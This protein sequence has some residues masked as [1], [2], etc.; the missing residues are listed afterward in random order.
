MTR[1]PAT[2]PNSALLFPKG[3]GLECIITQVSH[4][5]LLEKTVAVLVVAALRTSLTQPLVAVKELSALSRAT[6]V[7]SNSPTIT[8]L[9]L[10]VAGRERLAETPQA[11][12]L[13]L[14]VLVYLQA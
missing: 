14:A 5:T 10:A 2:R 7:V 12:L 4:L 1:L 13:A 3:V 6:S 11:E 8:K 9:L